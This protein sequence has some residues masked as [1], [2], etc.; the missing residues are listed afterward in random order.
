[1]S[2]NAAPRLMRL[3]LPIFREAFSKDSLSFCAS[4]VLVL[5]FMRGDT[6]RTF[7]GAEDG[8]R[9]RELPHPPAAQLLPNPP[10]STHCHPLCLFSISC[11]ELALVGGF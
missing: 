4:I 10:T 7:A 3:R 8:T 5:S 2:S 11:P 6:V 9:W 1:M